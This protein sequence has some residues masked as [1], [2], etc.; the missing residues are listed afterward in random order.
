MGVGG[1]HPNIPVHLYKLS[2]WC[3]SQYGA[4]RNEKIQALMNN[5]DDYRGEEVLWQMSQKIKPRPT[6][7]K[8]DSIT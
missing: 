8:Q 6:H 4:K 1:R 3:F 2:L 5:F 7:K